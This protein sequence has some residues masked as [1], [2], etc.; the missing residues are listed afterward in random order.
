[1][2]ACSSE[3]GVVTESQ[4][5]T[6][7][8]STPL[9]TTPDSSP[10]TTDAQPADALNWTEC[11]DE[12][13]AG[14]DQ[15]ECATLDVPLDYDDTSGDTIP[16]A[17][18]RYP[19][20][21]DREGAVLFNPGGPG[22]SGFDYIAQG[23]EV[24]SQS[25]GLEHF[26]IIG[27]DPRGV[28]RSGGIR[29]VDDATQ[30]RYL[31]IDTSPDTPEEQALLDEAD[32]ALASGC[33]ATYGDSLQHYSTVA[34]ARDMDA[35]R[36]ALGD[37]QISFLGISYG[38]YLGGVYAT[39][40]P[41]RVRAMVLDSAFS[42]DGDSVEEQW[43]TQLVGFENA[44][45][46]WAAWCQTN[47]DCAFNAPDVGARWDA[48]SD[49]LDASPVPAPDG[50]VGNQAVLETATTS[51]LYSEAEWPV[52]ASALARSEN[53][54]VTGLFALADSYNGRNPDGT[55]STLFQSFTII[56]CAS[57]IEQESPEDPEALAAELRSLAPR[58][59]AEITADDLTGD[60]E[61]CQ[62][63]I[64]TTADAFEPAYDGDGPVVVIGGTNDPAT[65]IR[66]AE[67]LVAQ[68]GSNAE[69]VRYEGEGHGQLLASTCVTDIQGA[70]LADLE[71]PDPNTTC[72]A[73]PV[74]EQPDWWTDIPVPAGVSEV[75]SLPG[76]AA[77]LGIT[78]SLGFS[79]L[80]TTALSAV[81]AADAYEQ[82]LKDAGFESVGDQD[83][84]IPDSTNRLY[85]APGFEALLVITL[86]PDAIASDDLASAQNEVPPD[87]TVVVLV[88]IPQ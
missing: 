87:T 2:A 75:Q 57:G 1:M 14:Y 58:F 53:G 9:T 48:L 40:F 42:P 71:L 20:Q 27:F 61:N 4:E 47:S 26:D 13:T 21:D 46:S 5:Q 86:G 32:A 30:D 22:G 59:G 31:Y 60:A 79:E 37:D 16:V 55:F 41:E 82:A 69:L 29:C 81:D 49:Q 23:G 3:S 6:P 80:R 73:D 7:G 24:I 85:L 28:D 44:F 35:I 74:V 76:T 51:A 63:L 64:G 52:L 39:L 43:S 62:D 84:P 67:E 65:P 66:W 17:M 45:N 68:M 88:F 56:Q 70:L 18:V 11:D 72:E 50:R 54:D 19:A 15:L 36:S 25:L 8:I 33:Q 38:T 12:V 10:D 77:A 34:T 78:P 83:L